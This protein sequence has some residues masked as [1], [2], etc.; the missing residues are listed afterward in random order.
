MKKLLLSISLASLILTNVQGSAENLSTSLVSEVI[1]VCEFLET[2]LHDDNKIFFSIEKKE[3]AT[4]HYDSININIPTY[5]YIIDTGYTHHGYTVK[6]TITPI[7]SAK[8]ELHQ[9]NANNA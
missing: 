6:T 3:Y 9:Q 4:S 5:P 2:Y 7:S 1:R 8:A